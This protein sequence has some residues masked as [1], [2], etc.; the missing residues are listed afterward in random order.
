MALIQLTK[1]FVTLVDDDL[2]E[3]LN[4]YLWHANGLEGRPARRLPDQERR[5]I[6]MYHQIMEVLP[7][8]LNMKGL[9][10]D[11]INN[12][13]LDN[14][15]CNL[16]VVTISE[17]NRNRYTGFRGIGYDKLHRRYKVYLDIPGYRRHNVGT[18]VHE[19]EA[20]RALAKAKREFGIEDNRN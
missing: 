19:I 3:E 17:N 11:H 18:Y 9:C 1:G 10:V 6:F 14:R 8:E 13:P 7:W 15:K 20:E 16:R 5:I 2:L 4:S 12:D